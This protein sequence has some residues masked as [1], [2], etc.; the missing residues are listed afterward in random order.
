MVE[1]I[2][3][4]NGNGNIKTRNTVFPC[5]FKVQDIKPSTIF[6]KDMIEY[7]GKYYSLTQNRFSYQTDKTTD[8]NAFILT[9]FAIAKEIVARHS[10]GKSDYNF[11]N[12]FSRYV[13]KDVILAVGLPPAHIEKQSDKFKNYFLDRAKHGISFKYNDKPFSF[14]IRDVKVYPQDYAGVMIFRSELISEY[15][16][17]YCI[18]IGDGTIDMVGLIDGLPDKDSIVSREFGMSKLRSIIIDDAISNYGVTLSDKNVEDFLMGKKI[19]LADDLKTPILE[20][21]DNATQA[22][23]T[24]IIN[25]LHSKVPDFR[26]YPTIFSG[27]G[28]IA[29]KQYLLNSKAFGVTDFIEQVNANAIGYEKIAELSLKS[30]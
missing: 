12:D 5:A 1:I 28:S 17:C 18:D 6:T 14:Y 21:I 23:T 9:L 8:D 22:F 10:L 27:G 24:E 4:D 2:G 25:Q 7:N 30:A 29:L 26:T 3:I 11:K 16:T 15:S 13:G 19:A 20:C